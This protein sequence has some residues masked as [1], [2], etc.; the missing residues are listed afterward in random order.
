M[1]R[2]SGRYWRPH[3]PGVLVS[4]GILASGSGISGRGGDAGERVCL[5]CDWTGET[6]GAAC[7]RCGAPLYRVQE[8][9]TPPEAVPAPRP[10]AQPAGDPMPR[11]S[12]DMVQD[13]ESVP[14]AV[15]VATSRRWWVIGG[16]AFMVAAVLIAGTVG[17]SERTQGPA[18]EVKTGPVL[19]SP[20]ETGPAETAPPSPPASRGPTVVEQEMCSD[21]AR[22]RLELTNIGGVTGLLSSIQARFELHGS[23]VGHEW[24]ILIER[25]SGMDP[26]IVWWRGT[27]V[28]S[29][30][31]DLVN[32][33]TTFR[34]GILRMRFRAKALDRQTGQVCTVSATAARRE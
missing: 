3:L 18:E 34:N 28:A 11:S 19:P 20:T 9:T 1:G 16:G 12:V 15:P 29:D 23:P 26:P 24:R 22:V 31:G 30:S 27:R 25:F 2:C 21:G 6:D 4:R 14:P 5:R 32:Q 8:P 10:R 17:L 33:G 7:S 13:D